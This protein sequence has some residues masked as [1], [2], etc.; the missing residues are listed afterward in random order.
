LLS[1]I[2]NLDE[3]WQQASKLVLLQK[4]QIVIWS[5]SVK[6]FDYL[7]TCLGLIKRKSVIKNSWHDLIALIKYVHV[8]YLNVY[9]KVNCEAFPI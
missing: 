6:Q 5:S 8:L 9:N 1:K 7:Q 4:I 3:C 2:D